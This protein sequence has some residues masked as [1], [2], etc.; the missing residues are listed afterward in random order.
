MITSDEISQISEKRAN[1]RFG[2]LLVSKGLLNRRELSEALNEQRSRGGRLG[3]ILIRL[4]ILSD[5]DV[6]IA[7]AEHL[8]TERVHLDEREIDMNVARLVPEAIAKR[9]SLVAICEKD[10]QVLVAM[11]DP[12]DIVA[13]DTV[14][15]KTGREIRPVLSSLREIHRA[16]EKVYHG[17]DLDEQSLRDLV[18]HAVNTEDDEGEARTD[19]MMESALN[20]ME[21]D[22]SV[23]EAATRAP[24]IRFVDLL[25]R[26]AVKSRASDIHVEPRERSMTIRMRIDGVLQD[27]VP[28]PRKMQAAIATRIKILSRMDIAERR[29]P[30]DGRFKIKATGR[31]IDVRVSVIPTIY[32]E[33]VVMRILDSAAVNHN[34]DQLGFDAD[35]LGELKVMLSQ[36]HGIIIVTGPTG[37]GKSTTLYSALNYLRDPK[38]NITTVED[39]V[40]YRLD[41]IN[42]IQVKPDIGLDFAESL[43]A[44]LRQ[45]P[46]IILIGEI[47]DKETIDIAIKASLTGHLV[48]ST[49]HTNDAPSAISRMVY[50][51]VES[52]LLASTVNLIIAQRLV[53]RICEHCKEPVE[54]SPEIIKRLNITPERVQNPVFYHGC[55]CPKCS[56]SGYLGRL[57]IFE[58]LVMDR[59][60]RDAV[61][62]GASEAKIRAMSR[63]RGYQGLL[64]SGVDRLLDG[65]TTA[66]EV[67]GAAFTERER[68]ER[69]VKHG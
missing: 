11:A 15:M 42:Q 26:Q 29:L 17:S 56:H 58:F 55:G 34:L 6:R 40:E 35:L 20:A 64:G 2:E 65:L 31:D 52:Y 63:E 1:V 37:S 68:A 39:P 60:V 16:I 53:R 21:A 30:Q 36:P 41:G 18:E 22:I 45:D 32:G 23:E 49:F 8:A 28:P 38:K 67:L 13:T 7:L 27:M 3:E 4:K 43:R 24:V 10:Q 59:E 9:F 66:E 25:L 54:V 51:G 50:M 12:L 46:D 57:P 47:R 44:I 62:S 48:L 69:V 14:T 61:S 33:K 19:E 5:E